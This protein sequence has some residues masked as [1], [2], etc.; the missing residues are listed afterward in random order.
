MFCCLVL[1]PKFGLMLRSSCTKP[2]EK[3][4][5]HYHIFNLKQ[6]DF[7]AS[8]P[9]DLLKKNIHRKHEKADDDK[10]IYI[11]LDTRLVILR[12][13]KN[14]LTLRRIMPQLKV[15][16]WS[17]TF[18]KTCTGCKSLRLKV[19]Q[20]LQWRSLRDANSCMSTQRMILQGCDFFCWYVLELHTFQEKEQKVVTH[21]GTSHWLIIGGACI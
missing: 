14:K 13:N 6:G 12:C 19:T 15:N 20:P 4:H 8:L 5:L 10:K 21:S 7:R 9:A 3:Q 18:V 11:W 17:P 2:G 16:A 1:P